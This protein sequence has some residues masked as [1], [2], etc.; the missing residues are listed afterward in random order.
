MERL[1]AV[2][3]CRRGSFSRTGSLLPAVLALPAWCPTVLMV[4]ARHSLCP[5]SPGG[6][7]CWHS[8]SQRLRWLF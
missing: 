7:V 5:C 8:T 3:G 6:R 1:M 2:L 4:S